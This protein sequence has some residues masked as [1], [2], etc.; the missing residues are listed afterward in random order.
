MGLYTGI[1]QENVTVQGGTLYDVTISGGTLGG[2]LTGNVDATA[3]YIQL[4]TAT[5]TQIAA[6]GDAVNTAGK[7]AGTIVFDT[8]NSKIKVATG[9]NANSTWVDADGTNAVT[10][11]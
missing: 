8:T 3:G 11:S 1:T 4:R 6:I 5:S 2:T 10:P 9:A 7:A